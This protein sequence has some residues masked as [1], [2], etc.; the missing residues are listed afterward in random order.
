MSGGSGKVRTEGRMWKGN[1]RGRGADAEAGWQ[2]CREGKIGAP[3]SPGLMEVS[4]Q[5][6][7]IMCRPLDLVSRGCPCPCGMEPRRI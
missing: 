5:Q 7:S 6:N 1:K 3:G 4:W 2:G